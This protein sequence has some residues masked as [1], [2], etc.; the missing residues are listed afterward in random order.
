MSFENRLTIKNRVLKI[1]KLDAVRH[2]VLNIMLF[3]HN[4]SVM[5]NSHW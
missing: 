4:P 5:V 1:K 2:C 3:D